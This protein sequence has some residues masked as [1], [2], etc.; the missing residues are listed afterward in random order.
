MQR[1]FLI[2]I[3]M[4]TKEEA[5]AELVLRE[6]ARRKLGVFTKYTKPDYELTATQGGHAIHQ[7]II[8][9]LE[10]V[11]SGEIKRLMIFVRPRVGK[12]E[13][14]S[15]RFPLWCLGRDPKRK[16]VVS[17]YGADLANHFGRQARGVALSQEFTNVFPEFGLAPDKR[18]GGNWET[19]EGG[20][21]Y[22]VGRG[23]TLSGRG[24]DIGILDDVVK[25]REEAESPT[26]QQRTIEWYTSTFFT[27]KQ[28]QDSAIILMM[29]RWN[30]NDL[31]G[32]LLRESNN[33]GEK[34]DVLCIPAIDEEGN[35][36]IWP[37][38]WDEGHIKHEQAN[39]SARDF[40][41]LYQQN[42]IEASSNIFR[43][44]DLRYF[45]SSD[46]E[47]ADGILKKDDLR[48]VLAVDPAFSSSK[49][50][51]DAVVVAL[52]QHKL[53][54]NYYL[55]DGYADTS[56]PSYT[57]QA[58][59]SM[60]DRVTQDGYK[61][62]YISVE[63]VSLS[64]DQTKFIDDF[65]VFLK[66]K[67]RYITVN[68]W[69]PKG[70]KEERIKFILEPKTSLNALVLRKDMADS[71]FVAKLERQFYEFPHGRHDDA[72]DCLAQAVDVLETRGSAP[73]ALGSVGRQFFNVRT[74]KM[75]VVGKPNDRF[76][77]RN[78]F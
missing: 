57:F 43:L 68:P 11:E 24:F 53:T 6:L 5:K 58:I 65:K 3:A 73:A 42:P 77:Y 76:S 56:A 30:V 52:G 23:G 60:Y 49:F 55:L 32:Y 74:G 35:E 15:I 8:D 20:G 25:D 28:S 22:T 13:L 66:S 26:I 38:K 27:R 4:P 9:K 51:D 19:S 46:F 61:V 7:R 37:G 40:A 59:L 50:S 2:D 62:D 12:S 69:A 72:I 63:S 17:S 45:L 47:K 14:A 41:A 1:R 44:A 64:N 31:A 78:Q 34:W 36:I 16:V 33:G 71:S 54:G 29:T 67:N 10:A 48:V 18:E 70:K 39:V 21:V 75:E